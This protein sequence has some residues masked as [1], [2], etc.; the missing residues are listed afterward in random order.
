MLSLLQT[1]DPLTISA[2]IP[3][4]SCSR[5]RISARISSRQMAQSGQPGRFDAVRL[6]A[7]GVDARLMDNASR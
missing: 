1:G 7:V 3:S 6:D 2:G 4:V 5:A